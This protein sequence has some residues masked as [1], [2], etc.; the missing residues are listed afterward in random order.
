MTPDEH[1]LTYL[2]EL[3]TPEYR[4][5]IALA[6]L[7][8]ESVY[9]ALRRIR[10][11]PYKEELSDDHNSI[12][13]WVQEHRSALLPTL[14]RI[15]DPPDEVVA[16]LLGAADLPE[17]AQDA[18]QTL[19]VV[20]FDLSVSAGLRRE[21]S[22]RLVPITDLAVASSLFSE[23]FIQLAASHVPMGI[24]LEPPFVAVRSGSI[25]F[26][27]SEDLTSRWYRHLARM[28]RRPSVLPGRLHWRQHPRVS[29]CHRY[30]SWVEK[31]H[32]RGAQVRRRR[33]EAKGGSAQARCRQSKTSP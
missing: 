18:Q 30:N 3:P 26:G 21:R 2:L 13:A 8:P 11:D 6:G 32:R 23:L 28:Q 29:R 25:Q 12:V 15:V 27:T 1:L 9:T 19:F 33:N 17:V 31:E 24:E 20:R 7:T 16:D 10:D 4:R 5:W 22:R 14:L